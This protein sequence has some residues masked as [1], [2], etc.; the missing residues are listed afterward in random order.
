MAIIICLGLI[1]KVAAAIEKEAEYPSHGRCMVTTVLTGKIL[2]RKLSAVVEQLISFVS[3]VPCHWFSTIVSH[4]VVWLPKH[5][6]E[7]K[8][9]GF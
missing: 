1:A 8:R 2:L 9:K 6:K 3:L 4:A 5:R 7:V